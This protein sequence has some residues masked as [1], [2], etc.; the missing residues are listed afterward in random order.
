MLSTQESQQLLDIANAGCTKGHIVE[1]R[2]IFHALLAQNPD[3]IPASIGLAFS[4]IVVN[5]FEEGER[6]LRENILAAHPHDQDANLMLGLCQILAGNKVVAQEILQ[7]LAQ[8]GGNRADLAA[9]LLE[10]AQ[11]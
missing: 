8:A 11:H 9:T 1:A 4:H 5:E 3:L 10:Q 6:L 7:P 2:T